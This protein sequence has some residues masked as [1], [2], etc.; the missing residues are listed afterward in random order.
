MPPRTRRRARPVRP[1]RRPRR[2]RPA[3]PALPRR[4][5]RSPRASRRF[6]APGRDPGRS[7][8]G[9]DRRSAARTAAC[10]GRGSPGAR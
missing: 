7:R 2:P 9:V 8:P 3:S 1:R 4:S 10:T 6:P 5:R